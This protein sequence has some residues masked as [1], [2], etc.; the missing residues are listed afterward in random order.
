MHSGMTVTEKV[1]VFPSY[2]TVIFCVPT[3]F[4]TIGEQ[5]KPLVMF[6]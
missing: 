2:D 6:L 3:V 5:I 1:A 4:S